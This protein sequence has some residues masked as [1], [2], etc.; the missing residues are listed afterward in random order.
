MHRKVQVFSIPS[1]VS[2]G[3]DR[4][5]KDPQRGRKHKSYFAYRLRLH[6]IEIK[7]IP[8]GDGNQEEQF[9]IEWTFE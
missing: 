9:V 3:Q 1:K 6:T 2:I 5:K 7:K 8:K 4:N